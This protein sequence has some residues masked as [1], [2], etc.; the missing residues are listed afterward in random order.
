M[1]KEL[2]N[3]ILSQIKPHYK[4][5]KNKDAITPTL[6]LATTLRFLAEGSYQQS[7]GQDFLIGMAQSTVSI[8][9][10]ETLNIL[11]SVMCAKF[12]NFDLTEEGKARSKEHF[13]RKT[14]FPGVI[15]CVD[16]THINIIKPNENEHHYFNRKGTHSLNVMMVIRITSESKRILNICFIYRHVI[17]ECI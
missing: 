12:I 16:G 10:S 3:F 2:F 9:L 17:I 6:K 14:G 15:G 5:T 8:V 11:E 13:L 7:V 1:S 4:A